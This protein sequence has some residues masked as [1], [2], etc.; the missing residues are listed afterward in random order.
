[1]QPGQLPGWGPGLRFSPVSGEVQLPASCLWALLSWE[2]SDAP[3]VLGAGQAILAA[4]VLF[5]SPADEKG[6]TGSSSSGVALEMPA[7]SSSLPF[8]VAAWCWRRS[9]WR[10]SLDFGFESQ[11][12]YLQVE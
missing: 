10:R 1:M 11:L 7:I 4:G 8:P 2:A 3:A 12:H 6:L 9:F 5:P